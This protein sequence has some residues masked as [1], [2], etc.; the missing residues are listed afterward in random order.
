MK[1]HM[2]S[3]NYFVKTNIKK[4][5]R[6]NDTVASKFDTSICLRYKDVWIGKP[7]IVVDG[8]TDSLTILIETTMPC[9]NAALRRPSR[10]YIY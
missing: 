9:R 3:F 4:I 1:Q 8:V 6:A 5:V 10:L 7:S 2:D